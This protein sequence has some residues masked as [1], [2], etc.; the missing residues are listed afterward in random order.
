MV[1]KKGEDFLDIRKLHMLLLMGY[2]WANLV[3]S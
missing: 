3:F 2:F 1:I